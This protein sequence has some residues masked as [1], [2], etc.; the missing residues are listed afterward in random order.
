MRR[1]ATAV[2]LHLHLGMLLALVCAFVANLGFF[3]KYRGRTG[4]AGR[5]SAIR[6][7]RR[8]LFSSP[9]FALGMASRPSAG[10]FT[11]PRCAR[12]DVG[13]PGRARRG[14]VFIAV[15]AERM[16]GFQVGRRQWSAVLTAAGL[17]CSASTLP[18]MHGAHRSSR[19][20][21]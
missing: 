2:T 7:A 18:A 8:A 15:M 5:R 3:Y 9:W 17:V 16:F 6:C 1:G 14:V 11:S 20:R 19:R 12:A 4:A 10:R 13:H 21:R